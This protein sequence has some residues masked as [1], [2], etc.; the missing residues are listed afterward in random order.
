MKIFI[1]LLIIGLTGLLS[2]S[3]DDENDINLSSIKILEF[4][5]T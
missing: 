4:R 5:L 2:C 1:F 3:K